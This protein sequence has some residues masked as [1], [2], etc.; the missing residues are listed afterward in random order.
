MTA[1]LVAAKRSFTDLFRNPLLFV[2]FLFQAISLILLT[3]LA[4]VVILARFDGLDSLSSLVWDARLIAI[5]TASAMIGLLLLLL[6]AWFTAGSLAMVDEVTKGRKTRATTFF[7][8]ARRKAGR[9][10]AFQLLSGALY[11]AAAAPVAIAI[12]VAILSPG[13][14]IVA[15]LLA[16]LFGL[17]FLPAAFFLGAGL[18][19]A[20][21]ILI[22]TECSAPAAIRASFLRLK[23]QTGHVLLTFLIVF[24][25]NVVL[26]IA[27][28]LFTLPFSILS[29]LAPGNAGLAALSGV[30]SLVRAFLHLGASIVALLFT[31]RMD[32]EVGTVAGPK[33]A[34]LR[35][36]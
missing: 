17:L 22:R 15:L 35:R 11:L 3:V 13:A 34:A 2:P 26:G 18:L 5:V 6:N 4:L 1:Y 16:L 10:F 14:R 29:D 32:A 21:P 20:Q 7:S 36:R 30:A 23:C 31:F 33:P 19:F 27:L 12:L 24:S 28:L 8:S 9:L 25:I